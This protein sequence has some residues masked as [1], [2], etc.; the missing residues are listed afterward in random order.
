MPDIT[1]SYLGLKLKNPIIASSS[2]LTDTVDKLVELEK[3]GVGAVVLKSIFEEEIVMHTERAIEKMSASGFVYPETM[4]YFEYDYEEIDD[5]VQNYL[6]LIADAKKKLTIPV[7]A[8]VNCLSHGVWEDFA[9]KVEKAGA[10]AL[11]LNVF[12]L[13]SDN[14]LS[15]E[16][17]EKVYFDVVKSVVAKVKIPVSLKMGPYASNL[18]SLI[19]KL[20]K[21]GIKGLVLFNRSYN[22]DFDINTLEFTNSSVLTTSSDMHQTLRWIALSAGNVKCDLA[23]STGVH[24]GA[25]LIKMLLAGASAVQVASTLYRNGNAQVARMLSD[26][27]EWMN[28]QGYKSLGD[29]AGKMSYK[30]TYNPAAFERVQFM[31]HYRGYAG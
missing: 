27:T 30:K 16:E 9:F 3:A 22:T 21:T 5:P 17:F 6:Q 23:A 29:F 13:P 15:A 26:L 2:G 1:T 31:K 20:S 14:T 28:A 8:S 11:E 24:D 18:S 12:L 25:G 10:D 19:E 7:I 4:E